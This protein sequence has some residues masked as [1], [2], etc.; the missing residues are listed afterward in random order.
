MHLFG[1]HI[2]SPDVYYTMYENRMHSTIKCSR[3]VEITG[4]LMELQSVEIH[5]FSTTQRFLRVNMREKY[6]TKKSTL[7]PLLNYAIGVW[8]TY[9]RRMMQETP[10][11]Y[12]KQTYTKNELTVDPKLNGNMM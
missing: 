5:N 8:D 6:Y 11:K 10:R 2:N 1:L 12:T 7:V 4:K 9:N 3:T